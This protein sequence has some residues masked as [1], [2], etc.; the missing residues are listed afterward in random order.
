M[1]KRSEREGT[2]GLNHEAWATSH[3]S[4]FKKR[5]GVKRERQKYILYQTYSEILGIYILS[6]KTTEESH[7]PLI[8]T[9]IQIFQVSTVSKF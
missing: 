8:T 4:Y 3:K 5:G 6:F 1:I 9:P 2:A 7:Y